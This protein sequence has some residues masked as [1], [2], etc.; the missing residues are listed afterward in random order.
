[1]F[2]VAL[3]SGHTVEPLNDL[4]VLSHRR[5]IGRSYNFKDLKKVFFVAHQFQEITQNSRFV[6]ISAVGIAPQIFS[7]LFQLLLHLITIT[8]ALFNGYTNKSVLDRYLRLGQQ[9][10]V[11]YKHRKERLGKHFWVHGEII[12]F[13]CFQNVSHIESY[14]HNVIFSYSHIFKFNSVIYSHILIFSN[15]PLPIF[16][17]EKFDCLDPLPHEWQHFATIFS[18]LFG[19]LNLFHYCFFVLFFRSR[20]CTSGSTAPARD[21]GPRRGPSTSSPRSQGVNMITTTILTQKKKNNLIHICFPPSF[22]LLLGVAHSPRHFE[23]LSET[24]PRPEEA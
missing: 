12:V 9:N 15:S 5:V 1:M 23:F 4:V 2:Q 7:A 20:P 21:S 22:L 19:K 18:V 6:L 11:I 16:F 14:S 10:K 13:S 3:F 8:M 24:V 17:S